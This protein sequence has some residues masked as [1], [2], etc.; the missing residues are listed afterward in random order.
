MPCVPLIMRTKLLSNKKGLACVF[1]VKK[2]YPYLFGHRFSIITDH[3]PLLTLLSG[4][5]PLSAQAY[6]RIRRW[7]L[8]LSMFEFEMR[9]RGTQ[10]HSNADALSWLPLLEELPVARDPPELVLLTEHLNDSTVT[11]DHICK[12][13]KQDPQLSLITQFVQQGWLRHCPYREQ[14]ST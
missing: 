6:A 13:T 10:A 2:F 12:A 8:Y 1:D 7:S 11:A 5:K 4:R 3:K 14:F 9:F